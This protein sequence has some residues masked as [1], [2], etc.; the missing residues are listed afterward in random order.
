MKRL[1]NQNHSTNPGAK[2]TYR[3][4]VERF[5]EFSIKSHGMFTAMFG[6]IADKLGQYEDLG[7]VEELQRI[8]QTKK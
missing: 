5:G 8:I 6:D 3:I 4:P 2:P 7:T 1:T